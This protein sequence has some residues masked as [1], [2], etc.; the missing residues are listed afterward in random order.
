M[1]VGR[2]RSDDQPAAE[3]AYDKARALYEKL[4][5]EAN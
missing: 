1:K 4:M 5:S 2:I 3:A